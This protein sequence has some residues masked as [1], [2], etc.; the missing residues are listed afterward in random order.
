[1]EVAPGHLGGSPGRVHSAHTYLK[2]S[3]DSNIPALALQFSSVTARATERQVPT[4]VWG[5]FSLILSP[6][7]G[8]RFLRLQLSDD[9]TWFGSEKR[10]DLCWGSR[11]TLPCNSPQFRILSFLRFVQATERSV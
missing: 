11:S 10:G 5:L 4:P 1:M 7:G 2:R 3:S 6:G 8:C 9:G